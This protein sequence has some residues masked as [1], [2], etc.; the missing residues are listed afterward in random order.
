MLKNPAILILDEA[1]ANLDPKTE[2]E[3]KEGLAALMRGRTVIEI[4]H[5]ASAIR[6][7]DN[8]IVLDNGRIV[9]SGTPEELLE[10]S[11]F[12]RKLMQ[13]G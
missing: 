1:T 2:A 10:T 13:E 12:Y 5:S 8:V 4:A 6:D 7:A 3:V 11:P 9:A